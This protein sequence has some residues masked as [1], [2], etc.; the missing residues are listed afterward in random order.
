LA[1]NAARIAVVYWE[2][3]Q[4][5][6]FA[7]KICQHFED[8]KIVDTRKNGKPYFGIHS[9][10]SAVTLKGKTSEVQPNLPEATI[11]SMLQGTPYPYSLFRACISRIRAEQGSDHSA[12]VTTGR[13][14]IIKG[15]LNR[16]KR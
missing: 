2:E 15:Y 6:D 3:I 12:S 13:A 4:L 10:L 1:P 14:G 11:K 7:S 8:M 9:I 16:L 5:K